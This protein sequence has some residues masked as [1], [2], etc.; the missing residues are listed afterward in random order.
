MQA[1][2]THDGLPLHLRQWAAPGLARGTVLICHG[3]GEHI[4]RYAHVAA[5][6][7]GA[8]WHAAGYDQR[9]HGASGGP[10]GVL[11]TPE[12]LLDDLGR[13]VD[14]VR[15]WKSGPLVLLGHSMGGAVAARFVADSVRPHPARWYREVTG[16]VLSSPALAL[17]MNM[18][19]HGLLA[20]LALLG[21]VAPRITLGNGLKPAWLSHDAAVVQAYTA[22]PL[23]HR[24]VSPALVRFMLDA[25]A[26]VHDAAPRW[27]VPTLLLYA[28][29][30]PCVDPSGSDA[31]AAAAPM[32]VLRHQRY[33]G[34]AHEL[35]NE[36]E[37]QR[38]LADLSAWLQRL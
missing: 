10:R 17:H 4:G 22:D 18:V 7:N 27:Q 14:A 13:V 28:G 16:L 12:A 2:H 35:F 9:G 21:T 8:G 34:L 31:F 37:R 29:A 20:L 26:A 23:V 5:H 11:P 25:G 33:D 32:A 6:L 3:L 30:D 1:L 36:P 38:V 19:Q 24:R 15:G